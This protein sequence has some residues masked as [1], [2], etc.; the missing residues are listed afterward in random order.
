MKFVV[1]EGVDVPI[2][3]RLRADGHQI[4][5][6]AEF[7]PSVADESVLA[8][9]VEHEAILITADKDFGALIFQ[10]RRTSAGVILLRLAGISAADKATLVSDTLQRYESDLQGTFTILTPSRVRIRPSP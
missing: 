10:Q 4:W 2:V 3:R 8:L 6:V 5:Y 9:A 1:Y 7:S